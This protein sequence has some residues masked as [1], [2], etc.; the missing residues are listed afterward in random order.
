ML[1]TT[2]RAE[3]SALARI[4]NSLGTSQDVA[5]VPKPDMETIC[6]ANKDETTK[7][8]ED[9][10]I[11]GPFG[12]ANWRTPLHFLAEE[13]CSARPSSMRNTVSTP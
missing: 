1:A 5:D 10:V 3:M 12:R 11:W 9:Q 6:Y 4:A 13:N 7:T 2:S 8:E